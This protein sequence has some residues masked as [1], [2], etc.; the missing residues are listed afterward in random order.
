MLFVL[1]QRRSSSIL[2]YQTW[3]CQLWRLGPQRPK[4]C[5]YL[6]LSL[7]ASQITDSFTLHFKISSTL[8]VN[9]SQYVSVTEQTLSSSSSMVAQLPFLKYLYEGEPFIFDNVLQPL[10]SILHL[11]ASHHLQLSILW[12]TYVL[13]SPHISTLLTRLSLS[14]M[15]PPPSNL[16]AGTCANSSRG[17]ESTSV[18]PATYM[19]AS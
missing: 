6:H 7:D 9:S 4:L 13:V 14:A 8:R 1:S 2:L 3:W 19:G 5:Y 11:I 18:F 15:P 10:Q 17:E 12:D 16:S